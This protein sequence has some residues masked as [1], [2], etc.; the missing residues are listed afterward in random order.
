MKKEDII[1]GEVLKLLEY[2][3]ICFSMAD[4]IL[5]NYLKSSFTYNEDCSMNDKVT[6]K[7]FASLIYKDWDLGS[8]ESD[9]VIS[10]M[11]RALDNSNLNEKERLTSRFGYW[12]FMENFFKNAD[13]VKVL[14]DILITMDNIDFEVIDKQMQVALSETNFSDKTFEILEVLKKCNY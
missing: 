5:D 11:V 8:S 14:N 2:D 3:G 4:I 13:I 1:Y 10:F 7:K 12:L 6:K 9:L